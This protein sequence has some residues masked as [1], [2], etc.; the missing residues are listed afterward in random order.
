MERAGAR[1]G[2]RTNP[3]SRAIAKIGEKKGKARYP[4]WPIRSSY[5]GSSLMV[6]LKRFHLE[7]R[8]SLL[9]SYASLRSARKASLF[10]RHCLQAAAPHPTRTHDTKKRRKTRDTSELCNRWASRGEGEGEGE[11]SLCL[12]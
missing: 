9:A 11:P 4:G 10:L 8:S 3:E 2:E 12:S 5:R 1:A 6:R 7:L